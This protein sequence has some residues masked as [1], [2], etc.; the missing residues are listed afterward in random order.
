MAEEIGFRAHARLLTMLGEQL[1]KNDR[2]ALVELV[3]NSFDADA[4]RVSVDFRGFAEDFV[5]QPGARIVLTDNGVGMTEHLVRTAW[6]NPATPS[7]KLLKIHEPKT[8]LGRVLQGEKG[9]GRFATFKLGSEVT[10]ITRARGAANETTLVVDISALDEDA[11]G[12]NSVAIDLFLEDVP[13][14]LDVGTPM[15]FEG[16]RTSAHGTQLTISRPRSKWSKRLVEGAYD[17]LARLQP[18][19]WSTGEEAALKPDFEVVFL[20]DGVDLQYGKQRNEDLRTAL[21]RAVLKVRHGRFDA[22]SR[23]FALE[24]NGRNIS[25]S[26]DDAEVRALKP[27]KDRFLNS[28]T[29]LSSVDQIPQPQCGSFKFEFYVFDRA[30][31][32]PAQYFLDADQRK[33]ITDHRIYLYRDGIRV[34]PYGDADDDWLEIDVDRGVESAGRT[35]SNDQTVGFIEIT[36]QFNPQLRDKTSREGLIDAGDAIEDFKALVKTV[37]RY[38]RKQY[39]PHLDAKGRAKRRDLQD[40]RIDVHVQALRNETNLPKAATRHLGE[41]EKS[42]AAERELFATRLSRTEQLAGVGLSVETASHDLILAGTEALRSGRQIVSELQLMD[43]VNSTVF[44]MAKQLVGR[45]EFISARFRDVQGLFVSTRQRPKTIDVVQA[46]RRVRSIYARLH[47]EKGIQFEIDE[48]AKLSAKSTEAAILQLL[49]N[50]VD[51]AT[52]WS[53]S[54]LMPPGVQRVIRAFTIDDTRLV[55]TDNGPGIKEDDQ[56]YIFEPFY[57]GKGEEGKGLGL[58]IARENGLRSGFA[59]NLEHTGDARELPGATFVVRFGV[60]EDDIVHS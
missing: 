60:A 38:L 27:F 10:L 6:M 56:P 43:L 5:P 18:L 21:E 40:H 7:K 22:A 57:S 29:G 51:N 4:T 17:D 55:L 34:Y 47:L 44:A 54:K 14:L 11:S 23:E 53:T 20:R 50:L 52:Y 31:D 36:Q 8:T 48:D 39:Q 24:V 35:L 42:L 16:S 12:D 2:V 3:K 41:L 25:L 37:L 30:P 59:L 9:I 49:I 15:V 46:V 33:V 19:M 58:Y 1:I 28:G 26:I 13:A 32:A 45:L